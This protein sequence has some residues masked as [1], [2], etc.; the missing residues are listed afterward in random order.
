MSRLDGSGVVV[1]MLPI[2]PPEK[3]VGAT[4]LCVSSKFAPKNPELKKLS[5]KT[6]VPTPF[7]P[8]VVLM[9]ERPPLFGS[10][11]TTVNQYW[12]APKLTF[13]PETRFINSSNPNPDLP[14]ADTLSAPVPD[15]I[16]VP[17]F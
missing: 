7:D 6:A 5:S 3:L 17:P 13:R 12:P 9:N 8:E 10:V 4:Q 16:N 14:V 11:G 1:T 15:A 2:T